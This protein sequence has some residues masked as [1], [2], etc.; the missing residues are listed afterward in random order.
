MSV[1]KLNKFWTNPHWEPHC[2]VTVGNMV[3]TTKA[4]H[5]N[6]SSTTHVQVPS[7]MVMTMIPIVTNAQMMDKHVASRLQASRYNK[8]RTIDL[9]SISTA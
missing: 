8:I 1:Q 9:W 2:Y 5:L 6:I 7:L 4:I 3:I